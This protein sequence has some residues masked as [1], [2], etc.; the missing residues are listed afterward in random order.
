MFASTAEYHAC[1]IPFVYSPEAVTSSDGITSI[2]LTLPNYDEAGGGVQTGIALI[3]TSEHPVPAVR[4]MNKSSRPSVPGPNWKTF[5]PPV[6]VHVNK[7]PSTPQTSG[8]SAPESKSWACSKW[9]AY[10]LVSLPRQI[11][12]YPVCSLCNQ[13][14]RF[15]VSRLRSP[16][17]V[18]VRPLKAKRS[19]W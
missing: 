1:L 4:P 2:R 12:K 11:C 18:L 17:R 13:R 3:A 19:M 7:P 5:A 14:I 9:R 8:V 6:V 10:T 16:A 15:S